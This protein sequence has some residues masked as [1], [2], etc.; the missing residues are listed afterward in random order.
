MNFSCPLHYTTTDL[1]LSIFPMNILLSAPFI[2]ILT[3]SSSFDHW[4]Q[5][6]LRATCGPHGTV[7][8]HVDI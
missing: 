5:N 4:L 6:L 1:H 3:A 7:F 2:T 8:F